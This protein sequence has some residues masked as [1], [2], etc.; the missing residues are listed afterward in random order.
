MSD[1]PRKRIQS[2]LSQKGFTLAKV[3]KGTG[4]SPDHTWYHFVHKGKE[5]RHIAAKISH[6]SGYKTYD[7][8]LL[9]KMKCRLALD[10]LDEVRQLLWCP[11]DHSSYVA[12]LTKKGIL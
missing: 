10:T 3:G 12:I 4:R 2:S 9:G 6:G 8:S 1:I 5:C 11:M 7:V